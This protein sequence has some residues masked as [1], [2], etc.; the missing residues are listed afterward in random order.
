MEFRLDAMLR[1]NLGN[2]NSDAGHIWLA[3][4]RFPT[5]D[6]C[7]EQPIRNLRHKLDLFRY[8]NLTRLL[9]LLFGCKKRM[10]HLQKYRSLGH[11]S[12]PVLHMFNIFS[13]SSKM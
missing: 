8:E 6:L 12:C 1:S 9:L 5:P 11:K 13:I 3:G 2:E 4:R 7:A 10:L